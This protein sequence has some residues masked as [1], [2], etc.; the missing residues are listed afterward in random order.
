MDVFHKTGSAPAIATE[1]RSLE[2][3]GQAT[4]SGGAPVAELVAEGNGWLETRMLPPG[5]PSPAHARRFGA[6]L[7]HTHAA[8]AEFWGQAPPGLD[9]ADARLAELESPA[10]DS[11]TWQTWGAFFAEARLQPYLDASDL[12]GED[13]ELVQRAVDR[14]ATGELDAP[15]PALVDGVARLHGDLWSG[16]VLWPEGQGTLIDPSAHGG[17]A[18]TDLA[19]L[20][21][22][23]APHLTEILA[24]YD[25]VSRLADGWRDRIP[26]HQLHMLLVH[27]ALFGGSYVQQSVALARQVLTAS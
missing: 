12:S 8:G 19:E 15:Q 25:D 10:V 26:M 24:G 14:I 4:V 21:V 7:A 13:A 3:L 18:E 5:T 2:W 1:T 20:G 9:P 16:N 11:P 22:F 27:V 6:L 23:G 17:H